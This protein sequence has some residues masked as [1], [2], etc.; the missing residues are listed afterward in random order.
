MSALRLSVLP[1]VALLLVG[2]PATEEKVSPEPAKAAPV[3][4]AAPV[5]P[6]AV[7]QPAAA[8]PAGGCGCGSAAK[9][10]GGC[11]DKAAGGCGDGTGECGGA[12]AGKGN[13]TGSC[14]CG[15]KKAEQNLG[16]VVPATQAK[17]GDLTK[18]PV[19]GGVFQVNAN[20]P[21]VQHEGKTY[22]VCCAGCAARFKANPTKFTD[23]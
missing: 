16:P 10:A 7:A 4:Q 9:A 23:V 3:V 6:V 13:G 2:C 19:S 15:G 18:C 14:G 5:Q 1:L 11:G 12:C 17:V 21:W 20:T 8:Q 22:P